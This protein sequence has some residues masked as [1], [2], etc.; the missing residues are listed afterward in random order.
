MNAATLRYAA[1]MLFRSQ[2]WLMPA[3]ALLIAAAVLSVPPVTIDTVSLL[4]AVVFPVAAWSACL[5]E[6]AES[7]QERLI[8]TVAG[9]SAT[10]HAAARLVLTT[11]LSA[12]V[13]LAVVLVGTASRGISLDAAG[14]ALL[15]V[16][17]VA[18]TGAAFGAAVQILLRGMT[19]W[20][21]TV[22]FVGALIVLVI[23]H[24][25]PVRGLI[26]S[27]QADPIRNGALIWQSAVSAVGAALC[28]G[29]G[30]LVE[31]RRS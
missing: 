31:H 2:R 8:S 5:V 7:E 10:A 20:I 17:V 9:R 3:V 14:W 13:P 21:A 27:L 6:G 23:P 29:L 30:R 24:A 16:L 22:V 15:T 26:E 11:A 18:L 12:P 19:G 1:T 4:L 28:F 25:L